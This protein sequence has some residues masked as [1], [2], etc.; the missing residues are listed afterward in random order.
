MKSVYV[1]LS[2]RFSPITITHPW[3]VAA[4]ATRKEARDFA[5][6]KNA[7]ASTN[8]YGV[9]RVAFGGCA[10]IAKATGEQP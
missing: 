9:T 8:R 5:E 4:F 7:K 1:V 6:Q 2:Q 3:L 10:A